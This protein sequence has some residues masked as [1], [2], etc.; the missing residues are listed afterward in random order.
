MSEIEIEAGLPL[1][2]SGF[3]RR[4]EYCRQPQEVH[5]PYCVQ[6]ASPSEFFTQAQAEYL[7]AIA[8]KT[9][10]EPELDKFSKSLERLNT[11]SSGLIKVSVSSTRTPTPEPTMLPDED[12]LYVINFPC[13][14]MNVK[15]DSQSG[16][17][18][19]PFCGSE[20]VL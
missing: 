10:V 11:N 18:Y 20:L 3:L 8:Y 17:Y 4:E 5:C 2:A 12:D 1:D 9:V 14:G 13:C 19:C 7:T 6:T 16:T 15:I